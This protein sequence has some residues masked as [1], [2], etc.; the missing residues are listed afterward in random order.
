[1]FYDHVRV[2]FS[3]VASLASSSS[4]IISAENILGSVGPWAYV[5]SFN[6][7]KISSIWVN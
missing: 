5:L 1:M 6:I 2:E 3:G 7:V 4:P